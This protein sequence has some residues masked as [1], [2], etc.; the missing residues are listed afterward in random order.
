MNATRLSSVRSALFVPLAD[1]RFIAKAH[2]RGADALLLDLEDSVPPAQKAEARK[3]LP[4]AA[5]SL[6]AKGATVMLRVNSE[7]ANLADDLRAAALARVAGVD[8]GYV[9]SRLAKASERP[10]ADKSHN[11]RRT[12]CARHS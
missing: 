6:A 11:L 12:K 9:R 5:R 1:E 3:R 2:E 4:E 7:A 10:V 8:N